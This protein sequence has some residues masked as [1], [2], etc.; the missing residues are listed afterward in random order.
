MTSFFSALVLALSLS[1]C[2]GP[3]LILQVDAAFNRG[4]KG[5]AW[6]VFGIHGSDLLVMSL[7]GMGISQ[8]LQSPH[9]KLIMGIVGGL[10]LIIMGL[11]LLI[12]DSNANLI[13]AHSN[14][15][16]HAREVLPLFLKG[17]MVN[18]TN[19]GVIF[20]WL[21]ITGM[22]ISVYGYL[23]KDYYLFFITLI[24]TSVFLDLLKVWL[25]GRY[26]ANIGVQKLGILNRFMGAAL[27]GI[28]VFFCFRAL[29]MQ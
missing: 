20:Y 16:D 9:S 5:G 21:T 4:F 11:R 18:I 2:V 3:G 26:R 6:V 10:I 15:V 22:S 12:K 17:V 27:L 25:I 24:G 23:T 19:P 1:F 8:F 13:Q 7:T 29:A 28:G 14:S